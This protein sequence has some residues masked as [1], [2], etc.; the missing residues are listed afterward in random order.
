MDGAGF[1]VLEIAIVDCGREGRLVHIALIDLPVDLIIL[2]ESALSRSFLEDRQVSTCVNMSIAVTSADFAL[3]QT[4]M[5]AIKNHRYLVL[6]KGSFSSIIAFTVVVKT[7][8]LGHVV[9]NVAN[10]KKSENFYRAILGMRISARNR[11]TKMTFLSFGREHH[12]VALQ[13]LPRGTKHA[14]AEK[15]SR[16]HH[17]CIYVKTSQEVDAL[18]PFLR[19]RRIPIVSGPETLEV[20]GNRSISFLDPDGNRVEVACNANK[21]KFDNRKK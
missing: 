1:V 12:D 8:V 14:V 20:A 16:L 4:A 19:R 18:Y 17:F 5:L 13:E 21:F 10:L 11:R 3:R 9:L 7:A 6:D 2:Y 15:P